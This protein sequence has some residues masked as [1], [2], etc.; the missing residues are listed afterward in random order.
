VLGKVG[1]QCGALQLHQA[2]FDFDASV[3]QS[4]DR[5]RNVWRRVAATEHYASDSRVEDRLGAR[6]RSALMV[7][8]L[9]GHIEGRALHRATGIP[10]RVDFGV[11]FTGLLMMSDR[12]D[13]SVA[14]DDRANARV[15]AWTSTLGFRDRPLH[16]PVLEVRPHVSP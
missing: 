11:R 5:A 16:R 9:Q 2:G 13:L 1:N 10:D 4:V 3:T 7:A 14:N 6:P 8:G 15:R 12:D